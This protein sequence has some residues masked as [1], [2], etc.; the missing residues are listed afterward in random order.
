MI[1]E[2]KIEDEVYTKEKINSMNLDE[3]KML[4]SFVESEN[5]LRRL[6]K[7]SNNI[8]FI[9]Y[10]DNLIDKAFPIE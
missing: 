5:V 8:H 3:L 2:I 10:I 4:V 7:L 6:Q 9:L 1:N